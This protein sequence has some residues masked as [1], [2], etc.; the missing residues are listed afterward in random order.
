MWDEREHIKGKS[1]HHLFGTLSWSTAETPV[2]RVSAHFCWVRKTRQQSSIQLD[3]I[4]KVLWF[5]FIVFVVVSVLM[6]LLQVHSLL[7][8]LWRG[9]IIWRRVA[10]NRWWDVQ[11]QSGWYLSQYAKSSTTRVFDIMKIG[12]D[13]SAN[14]RNS[15][16]RIC[17][18]INVVESLQQ[19]RLAHH[20]E[21]QEQERPACYEC[22]YSNLILKRF[23]I[24][25]YICFQW[26]LWK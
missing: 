26:Q 15:F 18:F 3:W 10:W 5:C 23:F 22:K 16:R 25:S 12:N 4:S 24:S 14:C 11:S 1:Y 8:W 17:T 20:S 13:R 9:Q 19:R 6:L 2:V 21:R 7:I